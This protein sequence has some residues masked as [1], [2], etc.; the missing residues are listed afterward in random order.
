M[1]ESHSPITSPAGTWASPLDATDL[2]AGAIRRAEP[3]HHGGFLYW[4]EGRPAEEGRTVVVRRSLGGGPISDIG[5]TDHNTRTLVHEYGGAAWLPTDAGVLGS[6]FDDQRL[7]L[8]SGETAGGAITAEP[9]APRSVRYSDPTEVADTGR[10]IWVSERHGSDGRV[11]NCLVEIE[12]DGTVQDVALGHDFYASPSVSHDGASLA[13][14]S[15]NHP[16][17]PWDQ[18]FLSISKAVDGRWN[19]PEVVLDGPALQQPRWSPDGGLH[20]VS[21]ATGYWNIHTVDIS[22]RTT[23]PLIEAPVEFGVPSWA[24][25]NRT[26]DWA[27]DGSIWTT[28]IDHGVA[29]LGR[30]V[31]D[32]LREVDVPFT[33]YGRIEALPDGRLAALAASWTASAAVVIIDPN[34]GY[35]QISSADPGPLRADEV[36]TPEPITFKGHQDRPTHAFFFPPASATHTLPQEE[37]PPVIVMGHGGPTGNARSSLDLGIQYWTSRGIAVVDVNYGGSTGFGTEYRNRLRGA[38]GVVDT[39]DCT[40]AAIHLAD[41]GRVDPSR[42]VI[43]G[44][45]A[46]G[47]TTLCAL[48]FRDAFAAGISR[49][50]VADLASLASDTHKFE[51]RYLDSMIGPWPEASELYRERSPIHHT[52]QLSTPMIVLQGSDDPVVPPSQSVQLVDALAA[53]GVAHSYVLFEGESHGFRSADNIAAALEAELSFL[54]QVLGFEPAGDITPVELRR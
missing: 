41:Q 28:W 11:V 22:Q 40:L 35:E 45:S 14:I 6:R 7:W 3:R 38:W 16:N 8:L 47:Y 49:Y 34:G 1:T 53:A 25:G 33:E 12:P 32:E 31:G 26:Y 30:I 43:K 52:S 46:G 17:M 37:R 18:V 20:V 24:F 21:D 23:R 27:P 5:P 2:A 54:G 15:W 10:T 48:V 9:S 51:A 50:G 13:F 4:A 42:L 36:S 39:D 19:T 44:G 29:R